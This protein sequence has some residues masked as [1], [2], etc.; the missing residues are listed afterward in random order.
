MARKP[1][2]DVIEKYVVF[3]TLRTVRFILKKITKVFVL[4]IGE[5][6]RAIFCNKGGN[7]RIEGVIF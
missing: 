7:L 4:V 1:A 2:R 3:L 5:F 6:Q